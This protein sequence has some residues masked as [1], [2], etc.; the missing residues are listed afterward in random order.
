MVCRNR[1]PFT[2]V[3]C[4]WENICFVGHIIH[5]FVIVWY[6]IAFYFVGILITY[7][8]SN[9]RS[10]TLWFVIMI[11]PISK[12]FNLELYKVYSLLAAKACLTLYF[13]IVK[14][15]KSQMSNET[16]FFYLQLSVGTL[17]IRGQSNGGKQPSPLPEIVLVIYTSLYWN[18]T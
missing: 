4:T 2:W 1:T 16:Y 3:F 15:L 7:C 18:F 9:K 12:H 8:I 10:L 11:C 5:C 17:Y 13:I 6:H 14:H